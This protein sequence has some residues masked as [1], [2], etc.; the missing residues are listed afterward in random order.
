MV[1]NLR[2]PSCRP[3]Y[4]NPRMRTH[5]QLFGLLV[6]ISCLFPDRSSAQIVTNRVV[7]IADAYVRS[8]AV[9]LNL[10]TFTNLFV[11]TN[12]IN[13]TATCH[14]YLKLDLTTVTNV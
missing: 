11:R 8:D 12:A 4:I 7:P 5:H 14:G 9:N 2:S 10:G 6:L 13:G 3:R 1:N